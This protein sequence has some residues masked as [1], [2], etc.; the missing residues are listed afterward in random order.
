M[1]DSADPTAPGW[2]SASWPSGRPPPCWRA[3][4]P[5]DAGTPDM[6]WCSRAG[7]PDGVHVP[8]GGDVVADRAVGREEAGAGGVQDRRPGPAVRVLPRGVDLG[9]AVD[10]GAVVG[11]GQ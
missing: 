11:E 6:R 10:V 8:D 3:T 1:H 7:R 4:P 9:L 5:F 2:A